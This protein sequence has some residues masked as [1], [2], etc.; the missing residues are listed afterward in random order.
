SERSAGDEAGH[1]KWQ[2]N[3]EEC[4]QRARAEIMRSFDQRT[5]DVLECGVN[6][7]EYKGRVDGSQHENDGKRA[8]KQELHRSVCDVGVLHE[9][10]EHAVATEEGFPRIASDQ[11]THPKGNYDELIQ[12]FLAYA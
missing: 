3:P 10:V 9:A 12:Q 1:R 6:R 7:K 2:D 11:I 4:L 8:V 5:R